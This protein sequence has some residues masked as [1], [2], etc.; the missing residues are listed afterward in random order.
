MH[1]EIIMCYCCSEQARAVV[2]YHLMPCA[3]PGDYRLQGQRAPDEVQAQLK[4]VVADTTSALV[5]NTGALEAWA[6]KAS[7]YVVYSL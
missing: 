6:V 2:C 1:M 4:A 5:H 7:G 3:T